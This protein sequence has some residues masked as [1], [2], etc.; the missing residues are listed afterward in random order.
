MKIEKIESAYFCEDGTTVSVLVTGSK[1]AT[2]TFYV[3]TVHGE[4]R[5]DLGCWVSTDTSCGDID[6]NGYPE[7]NGDLIIASSDEYMQ[8]LV[9]ERSTDHYING[10]NVYLLIS[11]DKVELVTRNAQYINSVT[12]SY[13]LEYSAPLFIADNEE[14]ALLYLDRMNY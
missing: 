8:S 13:Q 7:F 1:G 4:Y 5:G 12:S 3:Q 9:E 14:E 6:W 11:H 2:E 10:E